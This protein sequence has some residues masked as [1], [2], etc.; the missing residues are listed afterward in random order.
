MSALY[1]GS[2]YYQIEVSD[3]DTQ[4]RLYVLRMSFGLRDAL[5]AFQRAMT[6]M[7]RHGGRGLN[8]KKKCWYLDDII[9]GKSSHDS[10]TTFVTWFWEDF[11]TTNSRPPK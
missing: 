1:V 2:G 4:N 9:L 11:I 6:L 3:E 5:A 8:W 7:F 10:V